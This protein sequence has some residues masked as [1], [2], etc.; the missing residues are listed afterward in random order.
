MNHKLQITS[1][2]EYPYSNEFDNK[3]NEIFQVNFIDYLC[4][5]IK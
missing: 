3:M 1:I 2:S 4:Y 5:C